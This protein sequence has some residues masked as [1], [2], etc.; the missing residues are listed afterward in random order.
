MSS[1]A[2]RRRPN[3]STSIGT[4]S[5]TPSEA[6]TVRFAEQLLRDV[7]CFADVHRAGTCKIAGTF[8]GTLEAGGGRVPVVVVPPADDLDRSSDQLAFDG[9]RLSAAS[10]LQDW[11]NAS[12]TASWGLRT[13][14]ARLRLV[15]DNG[16]LTRPAYVETDLRCIF[17]SEAAPGVSLPLQERPC[18]RPACRGSAHEGRLPACG[19]SHA[20]P[21]PAPPCLVIVAPRPAP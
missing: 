12:E 11:L 6:A 18:G 10:A 21:S 19:R 4:H 2:S 17:E 7:F 15:R 16:S 9:R 3:I 20:D 8:A 14:G 1:Q 13:N 5:A